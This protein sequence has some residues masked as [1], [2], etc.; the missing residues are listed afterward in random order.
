[1]LAVTCAVNKM[2]TSYSQCRVTRILRAI[3]IK[4]PHLNINCL[5]IHCISSCDCILVLPCEISHSRQDLS[6]LTALTDS[7]ITVLMAVGG[8]RICCR[9]LNL[10]TLSATT[11]LR[12]SRCHHHCKQRQKYERCTRHKNLL[13][14]SGNSRAAARGANLKRRSAVTEIIGNMVLVS[15]EN[16]RQYLL[17]HSEIFASLFV[18]RKNVKNVGVRGSRIINLPGA[19]MCL[20]QASMP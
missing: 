9:L 5:Y 15:S 12:L 14:Y 11:H 18:G 17:V 7:S 6:L 4:C 10:N 13:C 20:W 1:M 3:Q 2:N 19:P 8:N 16:Y